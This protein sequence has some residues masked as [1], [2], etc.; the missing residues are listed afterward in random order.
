[1]RTASH[2]S[3]SGAR[4]GIW[5]PVR[6]ACLA[7]LIAGPPAIAV[8]QNGASLG[9]TVDGLLAA[10]R[11]LSPSLRAAAPGTAATMAKAEGADAL[12]DPTLVHNYQ[13]YPDPGGFSRHAI[14]VTQ[15][16]PPL[17]K[18]HLPHQAPLAHAA[19]ARA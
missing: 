7:L 19:A 15:P 1:M 10:G 18:P 17:R 5:P 11:Q 9:A 3:R 2:A 6:A 8:A 13:Y 16:F 4:A 12:H 14:L